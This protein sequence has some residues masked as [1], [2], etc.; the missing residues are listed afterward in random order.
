METYDFI[1]FTF[2]GKHNVRDFGV[3]RTSNS[4]RYDDNLI[5]P[6]SDK[7][8][9]IDGADGENF[10]F[11]THQKRAF[12]VPIAFDNLSELKYNQMREWLDGKQIQ[13]LVFDEAPYKVYSAKVTGT[14]QL[15]TLCFNDKCGNRVYKG[16]GSIQFTCFWPYAHTPDLSATKALTIGRQASSGTE[17]ECGL[18]VTNGL[19]LNNQ[20]G[21]RISI[22][23]RLQEGSGWS[24]LKRPESIS[25]GE[26]L[27]FS[28]TAFIET[29]ILDASLAASS[30]RY[31][32]I[33]SAQRFYWDGKCFATG[34][35]ESD[36]SL[37]GRNANAYN[38]ADYPNKC[39]WILSSNMASEAPADGLNRG[40]LPAPFVATKAGTSAIGDVFTVG[41]C[42]ITVGEACTN[43]KWDSKTGLVTGTVN[44]TNRPILY[45]GKSY[46]TIP[47]R[48]SAKT[49]LN[50]AALRYYYWYY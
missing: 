43:L 28:A 26:S 49:A 8:V 48:S 11:S 38:I 20:L 36:V 50:E 23:Y 3:Y 2:G 17:L 30:T 37:D 32:R 12:T 39:E 45:T 7:T 6:L 27:T 44:N 41:D 13:D 29:V 47:A 35:A 25:N 16:E 18:I 46:G 24:D 31:L 40:S 10:F 4:T 19:S 42:S 21:T 34:A 5:P 9:N 14:P 22:T 1:G 33:G 15:K